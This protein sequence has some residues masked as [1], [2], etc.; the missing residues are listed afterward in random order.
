MVSYA[1]PLGGVCSVLTREKHGGRRT[2]SLDERDAFI[3]AIKCLQ[4]APAQTGNAYAGVRSRY[5]DFLVTHITQTD[6]IHWVGHFL[7][8]H[9]YFLWLFEKALREECGHAAALPY[10]DWTLDAA[11]GDNTTFATSPVFDAIGGFGGNGPFI[12]DLSGFS[13]DARSILEV[14]GRSGGGC[15]TDGPFA[16]YQISMGP[17]NHTEYTPHCI[18]RD[19]SPWLAGNS[20][21]RRRY[22]EVLAADVFWEFT[23][24][25]EGISLSVDDMSL[26]GGGHLSVGG[27]IG[28]VSQGR[29]SQESGT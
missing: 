22:D 27:E 8:W 18:R 16:D 17:G 12:A 20:V 7:P 11:T 26:H 28:E 10:W 3:A 14:P 29:A 24:R 1:G 19:F 2:L 6:Y 25:T 13:P 15:I 9:R 4:A 21:S 23:H 5:D